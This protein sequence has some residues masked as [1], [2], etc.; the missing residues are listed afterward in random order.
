MR[1]TGNED[2]RVRKT[3]TAIRKAFEELICKKDYEQI[4]VSE[5]CARSMVNKKTFYHYY[6]SLDALLAELQEELSSHRNMWNWCGIIVCRRTWQRSTALFSSIPLPKGW[7]M[8]ESPVPWAVT[9]PSG[10]R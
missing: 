7:L 6:P 8:N 4:K 1:L 9:E 10:R 3:I 2:L 5:L